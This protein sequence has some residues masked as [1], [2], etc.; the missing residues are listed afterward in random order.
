MGQYRQWLHHREIDRLLSAQLITLEKEL[1]QLGERIES[2]A[3]ETTLAADN[4]IL[5]ALIQQ[6]QQTQHGYTQQTAEDT[7]REEFGNR[8]TATENAYIATSDQE[9]ANGTIEKVSMAGS[10][11]PALFAWGR[12]PNFDSQDGQTPLRPTPM[13]LPP[14]PPTPRLSED[15][16]PNNM[17]AFVD[18]YSQTAPQLKL[19]WWL[20]STLRNSKNLETLDEQE[21]NP[22]GPI[23]VQSNRTNELVQRWFERRRRFAQQLQERLEQGK[24]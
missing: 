2:V 14:V 8:T 12:L 17:A 15:L 10:V 23:D 18:A 19:P 7:A 11:S 16:L 5:H 24:E 1:A 20:R 4:F 21:Q 13:P 22:H 9:Q 3:Q 6:Y